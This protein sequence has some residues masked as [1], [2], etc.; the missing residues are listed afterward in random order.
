MIVLRDS[1]GSAMVPM[2]VT[3]TGKL[4]C[5]LAGIHQW[6]AAKHASGQLGLSRGA[7]TGGNQRSDLAVPTPV[8]GT[9]F[10]RRYSVLVE[11]VVGVSSLAGVRKMNGAR[12]TDADDTPKGSTRENKEPVPWERAAVE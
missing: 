6:D 12:K 10:S 9:R 11:L 3:V 5:G 4:E 7:G 8:D 2:R 1:I